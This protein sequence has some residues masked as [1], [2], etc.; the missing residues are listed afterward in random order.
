MKGRNAQVSRIYKLLN[1]SESSI[2]GL[3]ATEIKDQLNDRGFEVTLRTI[4]RDI[5]ALKSAGFAIDEK[6]LDQKN[7]H[8]WILDR[9]YSFSSCSSWTCSWKI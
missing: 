4:Y 5:E 9:S 3:S 6:R 7:G 8:K 2:F 1:L